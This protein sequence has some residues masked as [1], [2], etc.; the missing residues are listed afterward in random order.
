MKAAVFHGE[1]DIKIEEV[2]DPTPSEGEVLLRPRYCGICGSDL[3]AWNHGMYTE[4]VVIGHE[5]SA[6]VVECG[7]KVSEWS[8]GDQVVANSIIPCKKCSFCLKGRYSLCDNLQMPG[9]SMDG[10]LAEFVVLPA[11]TLISIPESVQLKDAALTEPLAVVLHGFSQINFNP[12]ETALVLGAGTIGLFSLQV[13]RLAGA[14]FVAVSEPNSTRRRLA[15][16]LGAHHVIDPVES[17]VSLEFEKMTNGHAA[18]LVIECSGSP[19]AAA[20]TFS[21]VKKGGTVLVLGLSE[22]PVEADFMLSILNELTYQFS[23]CGYAEFSTAINLIARG[24]VDAGRLVSQEIT[25]EDVVEKGFEELSKPDSD[26]VKI[27][28]KI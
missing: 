14:S 7:P 6:E 17:S 22:E 2:A 13:A 8:A 5:F 1:K 21:L 28:V 26:K 19:S 10:G 11:D 3:D 20:E 25:L 4:G 12:G 24:M 18:D 16:R 9:I 15:G 23:Y 27:L